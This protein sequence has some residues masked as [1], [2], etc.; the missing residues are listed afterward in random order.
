[1]INLIY[2]L[3]D[4]YRRMMLKSLL[5]VLLACCALMANAQKKDTTI[6]LLSDLKIQIEATQALND[7]YNFK[8]AKAEQQFRW[9][10]QKYAWHPLPY[11][12]LGLSEWWKILPNTR[13]TSHDDRFLSYMDTVIYVAK[14]LRKK[15][16][17]KVEAS[18]FLAAGYG[19]KGRLY[20]EDQR[21][22]WRKA[23]S[24]G[25]N[26]L[27]YLDDS[28]GKH[29]LSPELLFGDALYNYFSVWVPENYPL[30]KPILVFFPKG[31]KELGIKQLREVS[32]NAFYTRTEAQVFLMRILNNYE[33]D[34]RS[35]LQIGEYLHQTYPDNSYFHRYYARLLYSNGKFNDVIPVAEKILTHIDSGKLGYEAT[36]GRYAAFFLGH[37][38]ETRKRYPEAK[39][40]YNRA[41]EFAEEIEATDTG[42]YLYS[43][44]NLGRIYAD[45]DGN[46]TKAKEYYKK[47]KKLAKRKHPAYKEAKKRLKEL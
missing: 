35:A 41:M 7:L 29:E 31:D 11:F 4:V 15:S 46:K 30:L 9:L 14:R 13:D 12:L 47:V 44:L 5:I 36:S 27:K 37:V 1:M 17:H 21:K 8:F 18:F 24:A 3:V 26:A 38:Y 34:K 32:F 16:E 39:T 45:V 40:S 6:I 43:M 42:Y 19:F 28:K 33:N 20:S 2:I 23:A 25:K 22:Q 10:K